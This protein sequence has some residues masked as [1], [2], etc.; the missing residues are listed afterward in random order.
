MAQS[1]L[2]TGWRF[3]IFPDATGCLGYTKDDAN[4]EQSLHILLLTQMGE[5]VMRPDY[6]CELHRLIFSPNDN[7]TSGLAIHYVRQAL[8]RWEPRISVTAITFDRAEDE[9]GTLLVDIGYELRSS[10]SPR[11]LIYP[12]YLVPAEATR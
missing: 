2:G 3:P 6:G 8:D 7:T 1:F 5:R 12:F 11:N 9:L 10:S 4:V